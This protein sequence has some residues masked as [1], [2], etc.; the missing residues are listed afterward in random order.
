M[1]HAH[2]GH[3]S[4]SLRFRIRLF[5][6]IPLSLARGMT[7][8]GVGSGALLGRFDALT[9]LIGWLRLRGTAC[10]VDC[11]RDFDLHLRGRMQANPNCV[12]LRVES[13]TE[14]IVEETIFTREALTNDQSYALS[15]YIER[16]VPHHIASPSAT[17][18]R[19]CI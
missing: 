16:V 18:P 3:D 15:C 14:G 5:H 9:G 6:S 1:S 10:T 7:D 8:V 12:F 19:N 11:F 4:C 17:R 13:R 2:G